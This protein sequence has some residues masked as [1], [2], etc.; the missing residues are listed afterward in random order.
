MTPLP[1]DRLP[2]TPPGQQPL[3]AAQ[4]AIEAA[5]N[6]RTLELITAL[7]Q[8]Q[9]IAQGAQLQQPHTC[10]HHAPHHFDTKKWITI[11]GLAIVGGCVVCALAFAFAL[12]ATAVAIGGT[13]ATVC[14]L[15]LRSMWRQYM[16]EKH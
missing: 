14:L 12:A 11:G 4:A 16:S 15:V 10:Q 7:L 5:D 13:C 3:T 1:P 2:A 9:A 8:T 6:T